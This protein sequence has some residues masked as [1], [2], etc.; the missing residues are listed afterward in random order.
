MQQCSYT[1]YTHF[2]ISFGK[3]NIISI[4]AVFDVW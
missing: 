4:V 2:L 1:F 3:I